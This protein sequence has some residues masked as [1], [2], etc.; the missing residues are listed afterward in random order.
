MKNILITLFTCLLISCNNENPFNGKTFLLSAP[1]A[2]KTPA[3]ILLQ[4]SSDKDVEVFQIKDTTQAIGS[5]T[6]TH[7]RVEE[8]IFHFGSQSYKMEKN[9]EG[10]NLYAGPVLKY[11]LL[12]SNEDVMRKMARSFINKEK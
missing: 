10:F 5:Y 3:T 4:F 12:K 8:N 7:Y 6:K 11:R 1:G 2:E 9:N